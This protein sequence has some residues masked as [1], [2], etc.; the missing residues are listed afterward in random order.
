MAAHKQ[1]LA[2][3][4]AKHL[5]PGLI[6]WRLHLLL[7]L[8]LWWYGGGGKIT[9]LGFG[10]ATYNKNTNKK[11]GVFNHHQP[12]TLGPESGAWCVALRS[13]AAIV[14]TPLS[15][16]AAASDLRVHS[17][18]P[19]IHQTKT[20]GMF[21]IKAVHHVPHPF[22]CTCHVAA[23]RLMSAR[24]V[25]C[26]SAQI[27]FSHFIH[28]FITLDPGQCSA[29]SRFMPEGTADA[30]CAG[31]LHAAST[32]LFGLTWLTDSSPLR[33]SRIWHGSSNRLI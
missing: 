9:T 17:D 23:L 22:P 14:Y 32:L 29:Q 3:S 16:S 28:P 18:S 6:L 31:S 33:A 19:W 4:C 15:A 20:A 5:L 1:L 10:W 7:L 26:C 13:H 27:G 2:V 11:R 12:M 25:P 21:T 8:P 30:V 24:L